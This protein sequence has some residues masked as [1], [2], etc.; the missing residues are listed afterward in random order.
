MTS[1][2][3]DAEL[4][5]KN[6]PSWSQF[7]KGQS[8]NPKGRPK[9]KTVLENSAYL[10]D[11]ILHNA[12]MQSGVDDI[13]RNEFERI[14]SVTETGHKK[15]MSMLQ[16]VAKAQLKAAATG[17]VVAQRDVVRQARDL[18]LRDTERAIM[19]R[20]ETERKAREKIK[21]FNWV[22]EWKRIREREW[23][24]ANANNTTPAEIW[25]HPDDILLF[26]KNHNWRPRGP[27]DES[28][29]PFFEHLR[30]ERDYL[31][32]MTELRIRIE[33]KGDLRLQDIYRI[34]WISYD[35]LLPKR[36][37]IGEKYIYE[38]IKL[39][40]LRLLELKNEVEHRCQ[41]RSLLLAC[42]NTTSQDKE[43]YR[44]VNT[45]MKPLLKRLGYRS[46]AELDNAVE[47]QG[48]RHVKL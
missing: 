37:Q 28:D 34:L 9:K 35:V 7:K 23:A 42:L 40:K 8:G 17:N 44:Q 3:K 45:I 11:A 43:A 14:I 48:I 36:W 2:K 10:H 39:D 25:P 30:A 27:F 21:T 4:G 13:L 33:K 38:M 16:V 12:S 26:P 1:Y 18:E 15:Q 31:F 29:L 47:H 46:I 32:A 22:V 5:Y 19:A 6:P 20:Q 41:Y 24:D